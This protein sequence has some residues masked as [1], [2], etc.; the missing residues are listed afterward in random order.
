VKYVLMINNE[1]LIYIVLMENEKH[2]QM[3]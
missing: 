3:I 1:E 2:I